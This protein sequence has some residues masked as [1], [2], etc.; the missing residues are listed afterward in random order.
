MADAAAQRGSTQAV[1]E[2][3]SNTWSVTPAD[4]NLRTLLSRWAS[5]AGWQVVWKVD[6]DVPLEGGAQFTGDFKRAVRDALHST[7]GSDFP[8]QPCFHTN[9]VVRVISATVRCHRTE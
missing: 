8:L 9:A 4:Q 3:V 5:A 6:R 7:D 1:P 2:A